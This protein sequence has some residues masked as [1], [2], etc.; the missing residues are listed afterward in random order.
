MYQLLVTIWLNPFLRQRT[1]K[2]CYIVVMLSDPF[3]LSVLTRSNPLIHGL[4]SQI[5]LFC[6]QDLPV[7]SHQLSRRTGRQL[8]SAQLSSSGSEAITKTRKG[9]GRESDSRTARLVGKQTNRLTSSNTVFSEPATWFEEGG[10]KGEKQLSG[11]IK[12]VRKE[13]V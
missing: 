12:I 9:L 13:E 7:A 3:F 1:K 5:A 8:S 11:M 6:S 10:K 4:S 2:V